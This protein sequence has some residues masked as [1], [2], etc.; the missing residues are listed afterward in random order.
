M[1][2]LPGFLA[3]GT[4]ITLDRPAFGRRRYRVLD[5][6]GY[7]SELDIFNPSE[8]ACISY[9]RRRIGFTVG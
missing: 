2:V 3:L 1:A 9:G 7:G 4:W 8:A 5:H 6:I